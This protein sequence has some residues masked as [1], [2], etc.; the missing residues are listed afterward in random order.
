LRFGCGHLEGCCQREAHV[1]R[2][3]VVGL[4]VDGERPAMGSGKR[5]RDGQA[6]PGTTA[7]AGPGVVGAV[8]PLEYVRRLV[9]CHAGPVAGDGEPPGRAA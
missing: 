6:K 2:A 9:L 3:S 4:G 1:E 8:E 5:R 7:G